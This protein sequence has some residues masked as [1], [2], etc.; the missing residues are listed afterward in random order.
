MNP[1]EK[2][3]A[4]S[5]LNPYGLTLKK[6]RLS[7]YIGIRP[8]FDPIPRIG[9]TSSVFRKFLAVGSFRAA[10]GRI[11]IHDVRQVNYFNQII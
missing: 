1:A 2:H 3:P 7:Q 10:G 11:W 9:K 4:F 8:R 6:N 5:K